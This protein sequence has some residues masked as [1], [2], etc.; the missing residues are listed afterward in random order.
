MISFCQQKYEM[1]EF[2]KI[3]VAEIEKQKPGVKIVK[4]IT[5][6]TAFLK[7]SVS[8]LWPDKIIYVF[9]NSEVLFAKDTSLVLSD[10]IICH[11]G[12]TFLKGSNRE[13]IMNQAL[14]NIKKKLTSKPK[15]GYVH[16]VNNVTIV[17]EAEGYK[18]ALDVCLHT[19]G[20]A[21]ICESILIGYAQYRTIDDIIKGIELAIEKF[22]IVT[23]VSYFSA[24]SHLLSQES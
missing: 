24:P 18:E 8:S 22:D 14:L 11:F 6:D 5:S 12:E 21:N 4:K 23:C 10:A 3:L 2:H 1:Q 19:P 13:D 17:P 20:F 9:S 15:R 16:S 7:L